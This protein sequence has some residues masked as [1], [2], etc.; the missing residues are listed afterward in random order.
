MR[1]LGL[2][3]L[4][5]LIILAYVIAVLA[6][7]HRLSRK[8][9]G[10]KDFFL[11]GRSLGRWLQFFLNFG[12]MTDP[13][14]AAVT[15]SSVYRQGVGGVWLSMIPLFLTPY[16]WF[17]C[18]WFRR[19]RLTTIAELFEDRLGRRFLASVYAVVNL[20]VAIVI[21][22]FGNIVGYKTLAPVMA[23]DPASYTIQEQEQIDEYTEFVELRRLRQDPAATLAPGRAERYDIL[24]G[25]YNK[26][27]LLPYI[28]YLRPIPFYIISS[29]LV[30]VFIMLGGLKASA[31]VDALQACLVIII[32]IILIPFGLARLGGFG[33][34]HARV[35]KYMFDLFGGGLASE[36]TWYSVGAFFLVSFIGIN[37]AHGNMGIYGAAK[38]E[39]AA[40]VGA[41]SGGFSKRIMTILWCFCGL[42]GVAIFGGNLSD[43]D[44]V[45]GLLT[46]MLLPVGLIGVMIIGILGGK[47]AHLGAS[48]VVLSAL[49][50]RNIYEPLFPG[51]SGRHYMIVA[52]TTIPVILA[53]GIGVAVYLQSAVALLK[54]V[55]SL[56]V[57]WGAPVLLM[58]VW[59]KLTETAVRVQVVASL[60]IIGVIPWIVSGVPALRQLPQLIVMTGER[61]VEIHTKATESDAEMGLAKKE[62]EYINKT[63]RIEPVSVFFED[64]VARIDPKIPASPYEGVG[65]FNL[66]VYLVS[67]CG[68]DVKKF[69]PAGLLTTRY[70]VD[71][72]LPLLLLIVT[73]YLTKATDPRRVSRFF[74][75]MKTPV[76][77]TA[78]E[79]AREVGLSY[80]NPARFD[81]TK[82]FP[83]SNWEFTKWNRRDFLGFT[84]C[85]LA[86]LGVLLFFK[87]VLMIGAF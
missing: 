51:K 14:G 18:V 73:S 47:L 72:L 12:N 17:M 75:R 34:L 45:W 43:A 87:L 62:G 50:V 32:S 70:L 69:T 63:V 2:H 27:E 59:R 46:S 67:L 83:G 37:A 33:A 55:I 76:A 52:R 25:L 40:R 81:D 61:L 85:C 1:F 39:M 7:G 44:Q 77:A 53:L 20:L 9:K 10:E 26:G 74:A 6:L 41:V 29:I 48:S 15:A 80:A 5:A 30:A 11:A 35:P 24:K 22:G 21:I 36:Y 64:G 3:W 56:S 82:L 4:D 78:E 60:L 54:F 65:R 23:R 86:V 68:I 57:V 31:M 28:S 49:V 19:V 13:S 16:Y 84:V 58:F 79:D 8:V 66:E 38:D 71:A 42:L